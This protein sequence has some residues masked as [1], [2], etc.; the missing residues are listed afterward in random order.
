MSELDIDHYKS[1]IGR[2]HE[3]SDLVTEALVAKFRATF[4]ERLA[5]VD[6]APLG[7]HWCLSPEIAPPEGI[8]ADG[9]PK[10]GGF[11]PPIPL[12]SR[13]WA[14]GELHFHSPLAV[15][16][17]VR[18]VS[19][20]TDVSAKSGRSGQLVF[21]TVT[22]ENFVGQR[23]AITDI[24]HLV[25]KDLTAAPPA[26]ERTTAAPDALVADPVLLF[27]YSAITFNG[28]RIHYDRD[29][30][31]NEEG[32]PRL[33]VHG[34]LQATLL[35]N[36]AAGQKGATPS[37]FRYRGQTPLFEGQPFHLK[38]AGEEV[39]VEAVTGAKTMTASHS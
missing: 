12:P 13:M 14:G 22:H 28:H 26:P 8:A 38:S 20:I 7:L 21:V 35:M 17:T 37:V 30:A 24:Q 19:T 15:G 18:R 4:G 11:L 2:S 34:P 9:H 16:D 32:Y 3:A 25:Y 36:H 31:V 39:W 29:Y 23:L 10:R 33:V 6:G 1:W 5:T 27:R